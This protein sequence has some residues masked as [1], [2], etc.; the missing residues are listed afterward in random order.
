L[1]SA[2]IRNELKFEEIF[3]RF[4]LKPKPA[5]WRVSTDGAARV[6]SNRRNRFSRLGSNRTGTLLRRHQKAFKAGS[7][8]HFVTT[9]YTPDCL[10]QFRLFFQELWLN[11]GDGVAGQAAAVVG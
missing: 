5:N 8:V 3:R 9:V 6:R 1:K 11:L 2:T 7:V 10:L 4:G